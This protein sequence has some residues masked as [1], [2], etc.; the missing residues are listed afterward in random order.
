[1]SSCEGKPANAF[2]TLDSFRMVCTEGWLSLLRWKEWPS[3]V[4]IIADVKPSQRS[5]VLYKTWVAVKQNSEVSSGHCTCMAG[6]S[7]VCNHVGTVLYK[8]KQ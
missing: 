4:V 8:H 3:A 1:M 6:L 7:E 5:G 2:K